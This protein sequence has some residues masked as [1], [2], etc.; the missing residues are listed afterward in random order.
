MVNIRYLAQVRRQSPL[1]RKITNIVAA[2]FSAN[3]LLAI[4]ALP[5]M[6]DSIAE[7][8]ELA[9]LSAALVLNI[10]TLDTDKI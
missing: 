6:A 2:H 10:G 3:G 8:E 4:G 1:V 5:I 9:A 7:V